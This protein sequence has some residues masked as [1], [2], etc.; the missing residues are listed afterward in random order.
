MSPSPQE[1]SSGLLSRAGSQSGLHWPARPGQKR[2]G[3]GPCCP[4]RLPVFL[5]G[6]L[7]LPV[8]NGRIKLCDHSTCGFLQTSR[9]SPRG[10]ETGPCPAGGTPPRR[11]KDSKD[12]AWPAGG[13]CSEPPP[14]P[15]W[16]ELLSVLRPIRAAQ[17]QG[18]RAGAAWGPGD[19]A[20]PSLGAICPQGLS[21]LLLK[22]GSRGFSHKGCSSPS[23]QKAPSVWG[24]SNPF[25]TNDALE[26]AFLPP[27]L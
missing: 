2:L 15:S 12:G 11:S 16:P 17:I 8:K 1:T 10:Q 6:T 14:G 27:L 26:T 18:L 24:S 4:G 22:G 19:K 23:G 3:K 25:S 7:L 9:L 5:P 20:G 13:A 21:P